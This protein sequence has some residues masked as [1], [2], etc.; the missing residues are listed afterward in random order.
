[1]ELLS[2]DDVAALA[3]YAR[4]FNAPELAAAMANP[5][6]RNKRG[7]VAGLVASHLRISKA[8]L[9]RMIAEAEQVAVAA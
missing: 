1:M 8:A 7:I 9:Y 2:T 6:C 3:A 5:R 4:D